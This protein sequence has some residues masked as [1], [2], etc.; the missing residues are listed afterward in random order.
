MVPSSCT[1]TIAE[2]A[3][4]AMLYLLP[5][6]TPFPLLGKTLITSSPKGVL[7]IEFGRG[8]SRAR[9]ERLVE[10][11]PANKRVVK[12]I[13]EYLQ[14]RRKRFTIKP[15][16]SGTKFQKRVWREAVR[17]PYGKT[18]SYGRLAARIG[19]PGAARAVGNALAANPVPLIVPC[20]RIILSDGGIGGFGAGMRLKKQLIA[21]ETTPSTSHSQ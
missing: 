13:R 15:S 2:A 5:I 14:G 17:V 6:A 11:R 8:L 19:Q 1:L 20:H 9:R 12:E 16:L 4:G 3:I 7:H 21:L 18:I 10:K